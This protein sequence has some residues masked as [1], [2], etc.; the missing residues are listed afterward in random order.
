MADWSLLSILIWLPIVGAVLVLLTGGDK[1]ANIARAIAITVG[2]VS[3]IFCIVLYHYFDVNTYQ[4]QFVEFLPWIKAYHINYYLGIDGISLILI[5]LTVFTSL[6]VILAASQTIKHNVAQYM[7][8]FLV[9]QGLMIGVFA[10]L[11]AILFYVFWEAMLIPMYLCIG[12]WGGPNRSYASIKFFLYTFLG[13]V[14]M[15]VAFLYLGNKAGSFS[16]LAF[17]GLKLTETEQI[18]IFLAFFLAFAV[19]VPMWPFHTW[20]PDAHTQAPA[21]GSVVLAALMLKMGVYGFLRF[22]LPITPL[23]SHD[24]AWVM[25]V[26]SLIAIVYIGFVALAQKDIKSLIAYSSI[27]HMG[28]AT[29]GCFLIYTIVANTGNQAD[30][31]LSIEGATVQMVAHAFSSGAMFLG[32]GFLHD[33]L[34]SRQI[35]DFGGVASTMPVFAAFFMLFAMSNVGLP[36]T[37]G[38]VGEFMVILSAFQANVWVALIAT[39][40]IVLSAA[41]TLWM[42]AKVFFGKVTNDGVS[43]MQDISGME[44]ITY[45]LLAVGVLFIGLYPQWLLVVLHSTVGHLLTESLQF[46]A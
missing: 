38:F 23:A 43:Q 25:I 8:A 4:M 37:A 39:T 45:C 27:A 13:S 34:N 32:F 3:M 6:I 28:M 36:G 24:L 17:Y 11:D 15:L 16:I 30:A 22:S 1:N 41:Y 35:K 2:V 20:L 40:T 42:Y 19:K 7:A 21:G 44:W 29:L 9:L 5:M 33:R 14:L 10:S 18:L 26:L 31:F 12:M 46:H